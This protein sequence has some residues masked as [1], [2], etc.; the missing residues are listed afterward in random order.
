M[1]Y[2]WN[3]T[4]IEKEERLLLSQIKYW[5]YQIQNI[6]EPG[7]VDALANS[8]YDML[9]LEPTRT[10]WSS[11]DKYFDTKAMVERLKN[12]KASDGVHRKLIIA[13]IDIGEAENWRWYWKWSKEWPEGEPRPDDWPDYILT[14]DPDGWKGNFPVA[15]WDNRWKDIV[16]YGKNQG[17]SFDRDYSSVIDEVMIDCFDGVYLDWVEGFE[18]DIVKSEAQKQGKDP[19]VEML[20][21]IRE[22]KEYAEK[23]VENFIVIQQNAAALCEEQPELFSVIDAISQEA[24]WYDGEAFDDW[25]APDGYDIPNNLSLVNYYLEYLDKYKTSGIPVFNCEYALNY[26]DDAYYKSFDKGYVPYCTRRAL[27]RLTTVPPPGY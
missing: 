2:I 18:N 9:V 19:A 10:D 26:S 6:S 17:I 14:H 25:N 1:S 3:N 23:R 15:Y 13:Y 4:G 7:A 5:A 11:D 16:I 21:F 8:H 27:S 20:K 22:I 24:I 12:T